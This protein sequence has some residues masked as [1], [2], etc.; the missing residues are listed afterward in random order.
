MLTNYTGIVEN[1]KTSDCHIK[2]N[3]GFA[4]FMAHKLSKKLP[5]GKCFADVL[6]QANLGLVVA[7]KKFDGG[8][9]VKFISYARYWIY[10]YVLS[11]LNDGEVHLPYAFR[12]NM[13]LERAGSDR[14]GWSQSE[15]TTASLTERVSFNGVSQDATESVGSSTLENVIH[16]SLSLDSVESIE[17]DCDR[18]YVKS[19]V[20]NNL[21]KLQRDII[22]M[23]FWEGLKLNEIAKR[24]N[25][26]TYEH[27]RS[28]YGKA[29]GI[30]RT[31][32]LRCV[33]ENVN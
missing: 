30:L 25:H 22:R 26:V 13:K 29:L 11:Y 16:A 20:E 2:A 9:G 15:T 4:L 18:A 17:H 1:H 31:N 5:P 27:V 8:R 23:C 6:Q 32:D 7:A 33:H 24:I 12:K 10:K 3:L 28:E 14:L 19:C 21:T